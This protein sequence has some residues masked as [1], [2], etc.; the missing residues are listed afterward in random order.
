M[1]LGN[2]VKLPDSFQHMAQIQQ[3]V[4]IVGCEI[5]WHYLKALTVQLSP[6]STTKRPVGELQ[7]GQLAQQSDLAWTMW[8]AGHL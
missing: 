8:C 2:E 7:G 1:K 6:G 3:V 4:D 5:K